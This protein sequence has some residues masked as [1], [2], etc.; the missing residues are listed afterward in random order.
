M[1][2]CK[3][4]IQKKMECKKVIY[5]KNHCCSFYCNKKSAKSSVTEVPNISRILYKDNSIIFEL[6]L[7]F[8]YLIASTTTYSN[9]KRVDTRVALVDG[10][11]ERCS[12]IYSILSHFYTTDALAV[13]TIGTKNAD[14]LVGPVV[15]L[16]VHDDE[17]TQSKRNLTMISTL[18]SKPVCHFQDSI[19]VNYT[20]AR[21]S[22]I[23]EH[24]PCKINKH[25]LQG[26]ISENGKLLLHVLLEYELIL[27]EFIQKNEPF[28]LYSYLLRLCQTTG[29]VH[30]HLRVKDVVDEAIYTLRSFLFF[31]CYRILN[32]LF[33]ILDLPKIKDI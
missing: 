3:L 28:I 6:E 5:Y 30:K 26:F 4:E 9:Y 21:V 12:Y 17:F 27:S 20:Y 16:N 31:H 11:N 29:K 23:M 13:L 7:A 14:I 19:Y 18:T 24:V 1:E 10:S 15:P 2:Q 8:C 22:H 25:S 33:T 32:E